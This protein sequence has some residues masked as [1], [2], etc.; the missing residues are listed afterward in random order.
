MY[1]ES[2]IYFLFD[3]STSMCHG[4]QIISIKKLYRQYLKTSEINQFKRIQLVQF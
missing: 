4:Q 1:Q 2:K 3:N